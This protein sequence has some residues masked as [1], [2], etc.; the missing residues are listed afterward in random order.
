MKELIVN[1]YPKS[2]ITE[3]I[4]TVKT[5]LR[6]SSVNKKI[7]IILVTSS[8]AGEGKS[9]ISSNLAATFVNETE[10]VLIIDCDLRKGR[11]HELF[12]IKKAISYEIAFLLYKHLFFIK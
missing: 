11:Q 5:N 2:S 12:D 7:K 9:F 1:N 8:I 10:K 6:F 4:K 3:A